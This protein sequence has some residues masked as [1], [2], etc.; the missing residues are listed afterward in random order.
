MAAAAAATAAA[1]QLLHCSKLQWTARR[2]P[3]T[4]PERQLAPLVQ[5]QALE[6]MEPQ[7]VWQEAP[8]GHG[9]LHL[10]FDRAQQQPGGEKAS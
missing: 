2:V 6:N 10:T 3:C 9:M 8:A 7:V 5:R 1:S 4:S